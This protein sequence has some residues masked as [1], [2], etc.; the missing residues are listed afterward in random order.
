[1]KGLRLFAEW[2]ALLA[3]A[4]TGAV[5]LQHSG[6]TQRLD[7]QLLDAYSASAAPPK[8]DDVLIVGIDDRSLDT[9]G[10]WPWP[11][12]IHAELIE[13]LN[14]AGA[15][16]IVLDVLFLEPTNPQ[17]DT[18]LAEALSRGGNV[19]LPHTF[20]ARPDAV[21]GL[22]PLL[23]IPELRENAAGIGHAVAEPDTDGILRRFDLTFRTDQGDFPHI[24]LLAHRMLA[25]AKGEESTIAAQSAALIP[26]RSAQS[27]DQY[28]AAQILDGSALDSAIR[29]KTILI[30]AT[31]Q[32]MG[33]RYS[34]A[35]G[36]VRLMTGV[37][38][39]ANL[40]NALNTQS[41]IEPVPAL[42][43]N[44]VFGLI[45][46]ILFVTFW[47][48]SPRTGFYAAIALILGLL[49]TS[50]GLLSTM[51]IWFPIGAAVI[52]IMV[53]YPLWSWRRLNH[54]SQYLDREASRLIGPG[55]QIERDH[56]MEYVARQTSRLRGLVSDIEGTLTFIQQVIETAP[57][58]M[59]VLDHEQ[60]VQVLNTK[61][62]SIFSTWQEGDRPTLTELLMTSQA[63]LTNQDSELIAADGGIYLVARAPLHSQPAQLG[64]A[65][66]SSQL[67]GEILAFREITDLRRLDEERNQMLEFLS[68]DMRSPQVAI[69]GLTRKSAGDGNAVKEAMERIRYQADRT[70]KLADDFVQLARLET[71]D[72]QI[73]DTDLGALIE[74]A[75][76]RA[77][78]QSEAK[79]IAIHQ[80]LPE[81]PC[82]ADVDAS[83]VAR[84]MDNLIGNAVKYS[85]HGSAVE[86]SLEC[87]C[88]KFPRIIVA[89]TG[90]GL[91]EAR[92]V[93]PFARFGAHQS[94]AGPSAGLGLALVKKV[95]DAHEWAINL[96]STPGRGTRFEITLST[97]G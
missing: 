94:H 52:M 96:T 69:I 46:I 50:L 6:M 49:V 30:G 78:V 45:L 47:F 20:V 43:P 9:I 65:D 36:E 72:L 1:M 13:R 8:P 3:M 48:F 92:L 15:R 37:E 7:N 64:A 32:G 29:G 31:A 27:F 14:A 35:S 38:T 79:Q 28:S 60:R 85:E 55:A 63:N 40:L 87:D 10:A 81:E 67:R 91:P 86:V 41:L 5:A 57:D 83:L 17:A 97:K 62:A 89:D 68:H 11:R 76:D 18:A 2:A 82:F 58:A 61:A 51:Q 95:V 75:C 42:W 59:V 53:S 84:M 44:G 22:D 93:D 74:E 77:F 34:V 66:Q 90:P 12:S 54:V 39:Q 80:T 16:L 26:F 24:A 4:V 70:L 21:S 19:L 56:G 25:Q 88:E 73:E 71:P 33:D 23:P